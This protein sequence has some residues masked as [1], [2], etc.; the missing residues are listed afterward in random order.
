MPASTCI[1]WQNYHIQLESVLSL[2]TGQL[3][4]PGNYC[5]SYIG[6]L[7]SDKSGGKKRSIC[8]D[9]NWNNWRLRLRCQQHS[10]QWLDKHL[11]LSPA[12]CLVTHLPF[13]SWSYQF[14]F[15]LPCQFF[16]GIYSNGDLQKD[17]C[18]SMQNEN[19]SKII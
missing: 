6:S 1:L 2:G 11:S 8:F 13:P 16:L 12:L 15:L 5:T 3:E 4:E 10:L 19:C 17:L 7:S 9:T 14:Y 18:D